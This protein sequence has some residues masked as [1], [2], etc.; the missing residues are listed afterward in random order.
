MEGRSFT[1]TERLDI[2]SVFS[3]RIARSRRGKGGCFVTSVPSTSK[4]RPS[5]WDTVTRMSEVIGDGTL[6]PDEAVLG[7]DTG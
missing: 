4:S 7:K 1:A 5:A 2:T 6:M 3:M